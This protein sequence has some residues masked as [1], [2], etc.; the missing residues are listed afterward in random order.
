MKTNTN[1]TDGQ[2]RRLIAEK[3]LMARRWRRYHRFIVPQIVTPHSV[4][5][6]QR[7]RRKRRNHVSQRSNA[8]YFTKSNRFCACSFVIKVILMSSHTL[9]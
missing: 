7:K 1:G 4:P 9:E 2:K 6:G 8:Y 3:L 5:L